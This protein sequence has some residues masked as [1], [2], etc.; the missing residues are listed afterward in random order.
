MKDDRVDDAFRGLYEAVVRQ[1]TAWAFRSRFPNAE[2]NARD[3]VH[4]AYLEL[5]EK[6][7][8]EQD[9]TRQA[10]LWYL[11]AQSRMQ[12]FARRE[13]KRFQKEQEA[14]EK[15]RRA[16]AGPR[17]TESFHRR[18]EE[19]SAVLGRMDRR[20]LELWL[21]GHPAD[22][23][24]AHLNESY[25]YTLEGDVVRRHVYGQCLRHPQVRGL[26]IL[27]PVEQ[28]DFW[29]RECARWE[30]PEEV[31]EEVASYLAGET[32]RDACRRLFPEPEDIIRRQAEQGQLP[33]S[34]A[35]ARQSGPP[36]E[37]ELRKCEA[38]RRQRRSRL[39]RRLSPR[40]PQILE[41]TPNAGP[42]APEP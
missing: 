18:K 28:L 26:L 39:I 19:L 14:H 23:I 31:R 13:I 1:T 42:D 30:L 34:D 12:D 4:V 9:P 25:G 17:S 29:R 36:T 15:E 7:V 21:E 40:F 8:T 27:D 35:A 22:T 5:H 6:L 41:W 38:K 3:A 16:D 10:V 32:A 33:S 2:E 37:K 20:I 24:A 11:R